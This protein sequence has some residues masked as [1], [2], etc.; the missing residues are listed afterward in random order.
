MK[1]FSLFVGMFISIASMAQTSFTEMAASLGLDFS[2]GLPFEFPGGVTFCD[3]D[4]DGWD[5]LTFT[6]QEGDSL[7]FFKNTGGAFT[8]ISI[9]SLGDTTEAM[10]VNWVDIDN[11]GDLD[12][13]AV[14]EF[15]PPR[16]W[17][18]DGVLT[19]TEIT[20]GSGIDYPEYDATGS[21]WADI[22][23]DSYLDLFISARND[24]LACHLYQ[25]NGDYTFTDI[26]VAAGV[27]DTT[28]LAMC[29]VFLDYDN[30]NDQDLFIANDKPHVDNR[31]YQN[32]GTGMF[33][34][35]SAASGNDIA[36]DAM[37]GTVGDYNRDGWLD[38]YV[39]NTFVGNLFMRNN[40]DGTFTD[41]AAQNGTLME[42]VG[43]GA[44][45]IDGDNDMDEDLYVSGMLDA[46]G[47][48]LPSAYYENIFDQDTFEIPAAIGFAGDTLWSLAN[49]MGDFNN[50]GFA[51]LIVQNMEPSTTNLFYAND[52]NSN[53]WLKVNTQG[54]VSNRDGI[55]VKLKIVHNQGPQ[56]NFTCLGEAY[57]AQNSFTEFFGLDT[58]STVDTLTALWPSGWI[59]TLYTLSA[60]QTLLV[61]EGQTAPIDTSIVV[62]QTT[63]CAGDS[64]LMT[65]GIGGAYMWSTGETTQSIYGFPNTTYTV[66]VTNAYGFSTTSSPVN[67]LEADVDYGMTVTAVDSC[68]ANSGSGLV[69]NLDTDITSYVWEGSETTA[70]VTGLTV[71]YYGIEFTDV[72]GCV[73]EDSIWIDELEGPSTAMI[74]DSP[75]C[76][77]GT[78]GEAM[79]VASGASPLTYLWSTT[80]VTSDVSGLTSAWYY[81]D[82]T[83][84]YGCVTQDSV[85]VTNPPA[86]SI[87]AFSTPENSTS[88][89][90]EAW[91]TVSGGVP[92]YTYFWNDPQAQNTDTA[93]GLAAGNY[94]VWITDANGCTDSI[95]V[96]V[97]STLDNIEFG[98]ETGLILYPNPSIGVFTILLKGENTMSTVEIFDVQMKLVDKVEGLGQNYINYS[99]T[100]LEDGAYLVKISLDSGQS[101][102]KRIV[103]E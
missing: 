54:T 25:S 9:P 100:N 60:N 84:V 4:Q 56:W 40:G 98:A 79:V 52:G 16:L 14:S 33:T 24:T 48:P 36:I 69:Y 55:G 46:P 57:I 99:N 6:T 82:V 61:I 10:S 34:D 75:S 50:D 85:E 90:G 93:N 29:A 70:E 21:I 22:N 3:F 64:T 67:I 51:D 72:L 83:D 30:D 91:V 11:D 5:D 97:E 102:F 43:W 71:G 49:A 74:A 81:V 39:T 7:R 62:A 32:D 80:D 87:T 12:F 63:I 42:S 76:N 28:D 73:Y 66:E 68:G 37:S 26:T 77:N 17:R 38:I 88:Q 95:S 65:A 59:D 19:F 101:I 78:D 89:D 44:Q 58:V 1:A 35:V 31:L 96:Q 53:N 86:M 27:Y 92:T 20:V 23:N 18:C 47:L 8:E 94:I 45:W 41:I 2:Y 15:A 103:I 13:F